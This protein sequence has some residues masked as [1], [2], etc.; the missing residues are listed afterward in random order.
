MA[1]DEQ[2]LRDKIVKTLSAT[3]GDQLELTTHIVSNQQMELFIEEV[4][5]TYLGSRYAKMRAEKMMRLACSWQGSSRK[6]FV[7][8]GKTPEYTRGAKSI[9]DF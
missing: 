7:E 4:A 8:I 9:E 3:S 1:I 6:E 2:S 5:L